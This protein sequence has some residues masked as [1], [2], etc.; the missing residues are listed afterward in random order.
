MTLDPARRS[1]PRS[2]ARPPRLPSRPLAGSVVA[3]RAREAAGERTVLAG[4][5]L[6]ALTASGFAGYAISTG[7][8]GYDVQAVLP[9]ATAPFAW[10][11][12]LAQGRLADPDFDPVTTGSLPDRPVAAAGRQGLAEP[13]MPPLIGSSA[14]TYALRGVADGVATLEGREGRL[15]VSLGSVLPGAGRVLSI[16]RTGAGWIVI[17]TETIIGPGS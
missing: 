8:H 4:L 16:R 15:T 14:G 9:A 7:T 12:T 2:A 17:T 13:P 6:L 5:V 3:R 1:S 11:K 10:K